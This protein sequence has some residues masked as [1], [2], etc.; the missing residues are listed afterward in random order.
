MLL[1][2]SVLEVLQGLIPHRL[3][4]ER[5]FETGAALELKGDTVSW[6]SCAKHRIR[7]RCLVY[8]RD[9]QTV[10]DVAESNVLAPEP[11]PFAGHDQESR[12][13]EP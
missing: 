6:E 11:D 4:S 3:G 9:L 7:P 10:P 8:A 1:L 13:C 2:N 5:E 12:A